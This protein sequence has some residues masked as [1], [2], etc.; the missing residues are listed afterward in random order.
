MK[1]EQQKNIEQLP[2]NFLAEQG[3]LNILLTNPLLVKNVLSILEPESFYFEGHKILYETIC[4]LAQNDEENVINLTLVITALQDKGILKKIGGIEKILDIINRFENFSDLDNYVKLIN[5]KYL[6]RLIIQFGKETIVLGYTTSTSIEIILDKIEQTIFSLNKQNQ[7][8]KIYS[9]SEIINDVFIEMKIKIKDNISSGLITSFKDLDSIVQG[10][11]K[12]DLIIVAGR[13]SMGKTAFALNLGNNIVAKYKIPLIIFSLEM[14]RQQVIYRFLASNS[15]INSN[16]L[17]SGKMTLN[18]WKVLSE[19]MKTISDLPIFIDDNANLSI[20]D[21]RSRL[22]RILTSKAREGIVIIDYLQ[23]M[24]S[25]MKF[26]NRVQ[27]ISYITRN[28]KI[29][30]KEFQIPIILLS[31]LSRNVESRINKRPMLSD[32]RESGCISTINNSIDVNKSWNNNNNIIKHKKTKFNFKGLK[33]TFLVTLENNIEIILSSNHKILS[34]YG[35]IRI[36]QLSKGTKIYSVNEK[37]K[38]GYETIKSVKYQGLKNVYDKTIPTYHNYIKNS[39]IL[40]N[41]IEQ[42]A[43]IVIMIYREDYY[44]EN[45]AETPITEFIVAK[46]R[47]GPIGT[48]RLMFNPTTTDFTNIKF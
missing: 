41:S 20:V 32:L 7:T 48:A 24:K 12:S 38:S 15:K 26:D 4:E 44:A 30:A 43:D 37:I 14:S 1:K 23:L 28:L 6:R 46:H 5:E 11:Q 22:R 25:N 47:N 2:N 3:I 42:D 27:E 35:W 39:I 18:E 45:N 19:S 36:S 29:L 34:K 33:P 8:Q 17:K 31:Q 9:V 13:P 40:H 16:R 10:F 21:I